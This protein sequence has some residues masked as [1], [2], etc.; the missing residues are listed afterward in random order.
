MNI[1]YIEDDARDADLTR[2]EFARS[3]PHFRLDTV[4]TQREAL[5]RLEGEPDYDLVLTDLHLPDGDG[6]A[7]LAQVRERGLPL[8]VVVITGGGDEGS[9]VA[10]LKAGAN[11][12]VVK[13]GD[14]LARL[15]LALENALHRFRAEADRRAHPLRV[16]YAEHNASDVDLTRRHL[17]RHAPHIHLDVV[18]SAPEVFQR[19]AEK[20]WCDLLLLDYHLPGMNGLEVLKELAQVHRLDLPV[21]LVTG[22]GS[23]EVAVQALR[24]GAADYL[25]KNPGYLY[26][27]PSVLEDAYHRAQLARE[28]AAL[29]ESE[30]RYRTVVEYQTDLI[31]LFL[32]DST[33][34]FVN[35]AY[36]HYHGKQ[37][38]ELVGHSFMPHILPEDRERVAQYLASFSRK[39]PVATIEHR[40]VAAGGKVRWQQWINRPMFD[41]QGNVTEFQSVGRDVT[42]RKRAEEALRESEEKYRMI[43]ESIEDGY[44][45][46]DLAGNLA[47]FN[48]SLCKMLEYSPDE[49]MGLNN[50]EFM[51]DETASSVYQIFSEVFR[52]GKPAKAVGWELVRK[53]KDRRFIEASVSLISDSTGEPIGFR[54]VARDVTERKQAQE[55]RDRLLA[56]I[57]EQVQRIQQ[58]VDTMPE[59]VLLLD[60]TGR[61]ILANP[62]GKK[63]LAALADAQVEDTLTRLG[64][65]SLVELLTSP[66]KGLWHEVTIPGS[67][68]DQPE[69]SF[70]VIAR[71]LDTELESEN[72]VLVTRDVTQERE[73]QRQVQ[74]QER[75]AAVGQLAGGIAHDFNNL[76]TTIILYA[77]IALGQSE[78]DLPPNVTRAFKTILGESYQAAKLVR[79]ILDFSRRS[80]IETSPVD[81]KPFI[82]EAVRVLEHT[83]PE[84]IHLQFD[85]RLEEYVVNVDPTRIQQVLMNLVLNAR[86]AMPEGGDLRIDLSRLEISPGEKVP[87][88]EMVPGEWVCLAISDTGTGIPPDVLPHLFEPFFTTKESG[89]GTGLGLAQVHGIVTQHDGHIGVETEVGQGTTFHV[90]LPAYGAQVEIT[91]EQI[92]ALPQG[93]GETILLVED[94]EKLR[95]GGQELLE[96]L[97]YLVLTAENGRDALEI[98]QKIK[99]IDLVITD[100]VMPEMGGKALVQKLRETVPGLKALVITGY[101]VEEDTWG[102]KEAGFLD[103]VYKPFEV[104]G[105]A[106]VI[107]RA[108]DED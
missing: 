53:D 26:Q 69:R 34:T 91:E 37:R 100:L 35:Q 67:V 56:Q 83:I 13:G 102:L 15:P 29:R 31:C 10:A 36:C 40:A 82:K 6:L 1:L 76:L 33:L 3:V 89:K 98:Y 65:R 64:D 101:I 42:E 12:Y 57:Q 43:L 38:E 85:A 79:Q 99:G 90:Y 108:L 23:E 28:Q 66:P 63:D 107:R 27:L 74:R 45:E 75:L 95:E 59:G 7:L 80:P 106:Q 51:D 62:L 77:Q 48:D 19:L 97:G 73:V 8:A 41:E 96:S 78:H 84:S 25:V 60:A 61:V 39:K 2:R 92:A 52:T 22:R 88:M 81:L 21:V 105:L 71:P 44:Y 24:L 32:P 54:G 4:A 86:D 93:Q 72:W 87:V 104:D 18:H 16:L 70:E 30:E 49:L 11:D 58:I 103:V 9:A 50:R 47:F 55:E 20:E 17:A 14:Y 94:N 46:V 5:A 68:G